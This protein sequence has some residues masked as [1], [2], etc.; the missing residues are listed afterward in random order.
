MT[1]CADSGTTAAD[2]RNTT[3]GLSKAVGH[4]HQ[5]DDRSKNDDK[6]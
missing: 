3:A 6:D 1:S 2:E 5:Y 4:T